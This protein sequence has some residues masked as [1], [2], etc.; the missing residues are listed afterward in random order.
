VT[1]EERAA[2]EALEDDELDAVA[3]W[4]DNPIDGDCCCNLNPG[5][6]PVHEPGWGR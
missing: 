6:C 2:L 4:F 5:E 1:G 3:H